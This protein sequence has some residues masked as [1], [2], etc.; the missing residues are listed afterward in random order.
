MHVWHQNGDICM[1]IKLKYLKNEARKRK[2][3]KELL[4][5]FKCSSK[6]D[7]LVQTENVIA[8]AI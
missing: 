2:T 3:G 6:K 4:C 5:D 7:H 8:V 1:S